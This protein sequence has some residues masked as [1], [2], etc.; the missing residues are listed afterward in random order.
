MTS[1]RDAYIVSLV[2]EEYKSLVQAFFA[3]RCKEEKASS[4]TV[5]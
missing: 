2:L 5:S 4:E 3:V 1:D